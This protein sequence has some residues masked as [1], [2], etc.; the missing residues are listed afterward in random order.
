LLQQVT[1]GAGVLRSQPLAS[2]RVA[3][4]EADV[5]MMRPRMR[6]DSAIAC[7][8][9]KSTDCCCVTETLGSRGEVLESSAFTEVPSASG[10]NPKL[11]SAVK[12]LDGFDHPFHPG[13]DPFGVRVGS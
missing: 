5:L 6:I 9:K 11:G 7:G 4:H 12:K 2:E 1:I 8:Q 13:V 10:P 3:G